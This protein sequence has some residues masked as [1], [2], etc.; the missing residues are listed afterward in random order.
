MEIKEEGLYADSDDSDVDEEDLENYK[1]F[2]HQQESEKYFC[3]VTGA[4]FNPA[5]LRLLLDAIRQ[6]RGDPDCE[7]WSKHVAVLVVESCNVS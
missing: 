4:H 2:H 3:P 1:G 5:D 7:Q 6:Q